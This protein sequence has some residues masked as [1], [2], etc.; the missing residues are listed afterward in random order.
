MAED[1]SQLVVKVISDGISDAT[2]QLNDLAAASDKAEGATKKLGTAAV[3]Q[4][5]GEKK[6]TDAIE[7]LL[8]R[9][10]KQVDLLGANNSARN[11]YNIL[12]AR[13]T[14]AQIDDAKAL[15]AT[16]D[17]FKQQEIQI[18]RDIVA[19]EA[20]GNS[21]KALSAEALKNNAAIDTN[22]NYH[23]VNT[24]AVRE[25]AVLLHEATQGS[26]KRFGGSLIVLSERLDILPRLFGGVSSAAGALGV[27]VGVL[28]GGFVA[29]AAAVTAAGIT[30]AHSHE[31]LKELRNTVILTGGSIGLTG[32]R[33]YEL[34]DAAGQTTGNI[35]K[36]RDTFIELGKT[37]KFSADQIAGIT[38]VALELEQT[39]GQ[40]VETTIKQFEK[41]AAEPLGNTEKSYNK[42]ANSAAELNNQLHFLTPEVFALIT[43]LDRQG[44]SAEA[45]A[46]SIKALQ[47]AD[48]L[49]IEETRKNLTEF[50]SW[51]EEHAAKWHSG[52][53]HIF[54]AESNIE[55]VKRLKEELES[56]DKASAK[57]SDSF[58]SIF[59]GQSRAGLG[60]R[61][62]L[63]NQLSSAQKTQKEADDK[64]TAQR[65]KATEDQELILVLQARN[66][67]TISEK[68][69]ET[70]KEAEAKF[71]AE[72][73][74]LKAKAAS[75]RVAA[76][77]S[78]NAQELA[79]VKALEDSLTDAQIAAQKKALQRKKDSKDKKETGTEQAE[80]D[81]ELS[82]I[83]EFQIAQDDLYKRGLEE[84]KSIAAA[85]HTLGV[86][87]L[88]I[89]KKLYDDEIKALAENY[90]K[91]FDI[92]E[93]FKK[94]STTTP[95]Q[96]QQATKAQQD[97]QNSYL[98]SQG[99][100][101]LALAKDEHDT[102]KIAEEDQNKIL[103][104]IETRGQAETKRVQD[105]LNAALFQEASIGRLKSQAIDYEARRVD[106]SIT[107]L[108]VQEAI[109]NQVISDNERYSKSEQQAAKES[110]VHIQQQII[111][112][113]Q[114]SAIKKK[115]ADDQ[116][117]VE[118]QDR[119]TKNLD[120]ALAAAKRF[121]K[122]LTD[123]FSN[124]GKAFGGIVVAFA[125]F[126][127]DQDTANV[128]FS[129]AAQD[130]QSQ[131]KAK[132]DLQEETATAQL[133]GIGNI[134]E[135]SK[136]AFNEQ[137]RGYQ[138]VDA[139]SKVFHAALLARNLA[140]TVSGVIAGAAQFFGQSGWGG[141]AGVAAMG[142]TL[143]A[144]GY[145]ITTASHS[146]GQS[147]A[148]VQKTQG[149]G[150]VLG[151]STAKSES[152]TKSLEAIKSNT[153]VTLPLTQQIAGSLKNIE[154]AIAGVANFV[155]RSIGVAQGTNLGIKEGQLNAKGSPTDFI[156]N[157]LTQF[158]KGLLGPIV[159]GKIAEIGNNLWG[160][161]TQKI[162]DSG[163]Q[164]AGT[165]AQ[166][167]IGKGFEQYASVDTT[168]SSFF[169]LSKNTKNQVITQGLSSEL[170]NQF[171]LIFSGL[172]KTLKL[173]APSLGKD[174]DAVGK[175]IESFAFETTK[176]SLKDL[177]GDELTKAINNVISKALD[178]ISQ[179]AFPELDKFRNVGEGY[180]QTVVRVA[181]GIEQA[182]SALSEFNIKA[183]SYTDIIDKQSDVALSIVQQSIALK[184]G[185]SGVEDV[186]KNITSSADDVITAY[187]TLVQLRR[188][189]SNAGLGTNLNLDTIIGAGGLD[190]L[191][192][193]V[194][195]YTDKYLTSGEKLA[196]E[197]NNVSAAFAAIGEKL[198][199]S[200]DQLRS[201][202][203]AAAKIGDQA[204]VGKLLA[205]A[206]IYDTL[207]TDAD[208]FGTGIAAALGKDQESAL[209][210]IKALDTAN[211]SFNK[212][213]TAVNQQK[214]AIESNYQAQT[215]ALKSQHEGIV[216]NIKANAAAI[217]A[218]GA[219]D[220]QNTISRLANLQAANAAAKIANDAAISDTENRVSGLNNILKSLS[221]AITATSTVSPEDAYKNALATVKSAS[222]SK[223]ISGVAGLDDAIKTLQKP[224]E[225]SYSTFLEFQTAQATANDALTSLQ[226]ASDSQLTDAQKQLVALNVLKDSIDNESQ[227]LQ[228]ALQSVV[229]DTTTASQKA[230]DA[231]DARYKSAQDALDVKH[232]EDIAKLD[233]ILRNA[234]DQLDVLNR[235]YTATVSLTNA[236]GSFNASIISATKAATT[237]AATGGV[238]S[239][240]SAS[241][242]D[243]VKSLY[244]SLLGREGESAGVAFH[245]Q[246]L[247][248]GLSK[249]QVIQGFLNSA[250][251]KALHPS[252]D[253][254]TNQVPNDMLANIHKGE[255]IIPAADN[256]ELMRRLSDNEQVIN[257]N[258]LADKVDNLIEAI[259][260]GDTAKINKSNDVYRVIRD[261]DSNGLPPVRP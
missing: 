218:Q 239:N 119:T 76:D 249:D 213:T 173:A 27:S 150:S 174:A 222:T 39:A 259:T 110:L 236:I 87:Q 146:G 85:D 86:E 152:I 98:K 30:F 8:D 35:S 78:G 136:G 231:E 54:E 42:V 23:R 47:D 201:W 94:L 95:V 91:Q 168:K 89:R 147:A 207:I 158:S 159:G 10:A 109:Y 52:W 227:A 45:S 111:L 182:S 223:D 70:W 251:Y 193:A 164:F 183:I 126:N 82:K 127:K 132:K 247:A 97:E 195:D 144:L 59:T 125:Q 9:M 48:K 170:S 219:I 217:D 66:T 105:E 72:T 234:Q 243:F 25:G 240:V 177:K 151:D 161:V 246:G 122:G 61:K 64:V 188:D 17:A 252:F 256:A 7:K 171:G 24:S 221:T 62:D 20:K 229:D 2:K 29:V 197:T 26:W 257:G 175:A 56:F 143:A 180:A 88:N 133:T 100:I 41:L 165:V 19:F 13:G 43:Q 38:K 63:E 235:S 156:S 55:K 135:A 71:D 14:Q 107:W 192:K 84:S 53:V 230:L 198:P 233:E 104:A 33:L 189:L 73:V 106:D 16:V 123:A 130:E 210:L 116:R 140:A 260:R 93:K 242:T 18:K 68:G 44:K 138:A 108:Q 225:N 101:Q 21:I 250:E 224:L 191:T 112:N 128:K 81:T 185:A 77:K 145:S 141:F 204:Q 79:S 83:K 129:K 261:W 154:T 114:L 212:L 187:R 1:I 124:V 228:Q 102:A 148:D 131:I 50:G 255:R 203:E 99:A 31:Q 22:T 215:S 49:R 253:I 6:A 75:D 139:I 241:N 202:I 32:D 196:G 220:K 80:R 200:R 199:E 60:S 28:L 74:R 120:E 149:T 172:E 40:A 134:L 121:E 237:V 208:S 190:K 96:R 176:I 211:S 166:L 178:D 58:W 34:A 12:V 169:G 153:D 117:K 181:T 103:R 4:A 157:T 226:T 37:G 206:G 69:H 184:E 238:N 248:A 11:A 115:A 245:V 137:S 57:A 194:A 65:K 162:I 3:V 5:D 15:G 155:A 209:A 163:I 46:L 92:Q 205:L 36:A 244:S 179:T 67:L 160:K 214:A 216:A 167:Q 113:G 254:G 186:I 258:T 118:A 90:L 51:Y 232:T 142:V